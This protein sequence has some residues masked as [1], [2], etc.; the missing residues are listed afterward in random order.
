MIQILT[1]NLVTLLLGSNFG[2]I[3]GAIFG[4]RFKVS[5]LVQIFKTFA[6]KENILAS[7]YAAQNTSVVMA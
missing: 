4:P 3:L 5:E 6:A 7:K 1:P 2:T